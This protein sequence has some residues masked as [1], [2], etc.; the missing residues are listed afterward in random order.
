MEDSEPTDNEYTPLSSAEEKMKG[1][2]FDEVLTVLDK[3]SVAQIENFTNSADIHIA[4]IHDIENA[5]VNNGR[6]FG[7][8]SGIIEQTSVN[9]HLFTLNTQRAVYPKN[10]HLSEFII[11]HLPQ[12][13][14]S[15][16][17]DSA[18][19]PGLIQEALQERAD[20]PNRY[21]AKASA[22]LRSWNKFTAEVRNGKFI[23]IPVEFTGSQ[24]VL[25]PVAPVAIDA[26]ERLWAVMQEACIHVEDRQ[27]RRVLG[28]ARKN[29]QIIFSDPCIDLFFTI[30]NENGTKNDFWVSVGVGFTNDFATHRVLNSL[31]RDE[32]QFF[33]DFIRSIQLDDEDIREHGEIVATMVEDGVLPTECALEIE[34]EGEFDEEDND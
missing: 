27:L 8:I 30:A 21:N 13:I 14:R 2:M 28:S 34:E 24:S 22:I 17:A 4:T 7:L 19:E 1:R 18:P 15:T 26:T 3:E 6:Q 9:G 5:S 31:Q 20:F 29:I 16:V 33:A 12:D 25:P 32:R 11:N 23:N 10:S